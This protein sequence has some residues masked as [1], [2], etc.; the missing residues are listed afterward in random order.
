MK[1]KITLL[2]IMILLLT[3]C[4]SINNI[5]Y[6]EII[7]SV[8]TSNYE[9]TNTYRKGYKYYL[10]NGMDSVNTKDFNEIIEDKYYNDYLYVDAVSYYNRVIED[11]QKD[12]NAY[13]SEKINFEDKF[14]YI[15]VNKQ[16]NDKYFIEIMYNYAK[17]EVIVDEKDLNKAICNSIIIL[18]SINYNNDILSNIVGDNILEFN[19]EVLDIFK[20]KKE[21]SNF[22]EV[23]EN[24]VYED[25]EEEKDPDLVD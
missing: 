16:K 9:L 7:T 2:G 21:K 3:G 12:D 6:Q 13:Y 19:E 23:E 11:Y 17:I 18:S 4:T 14:G 5:S 10:P 1:K 20:A 15:E 22:L 24:N 8:V 25:V